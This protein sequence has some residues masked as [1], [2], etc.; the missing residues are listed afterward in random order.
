MVRSFQYRS[1]RLHTRFRIEFFSAN[2]RHTGECTDLSPDGLRARLTTEIAAGTEGW[3]DL[4]I[5]GRTQRVRAVVANLEHDD[6]GFSFRTR[7]P[8]ESQALRDLVSEVGGISW[9][10]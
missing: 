8:E 1:P 9:I 10:D 2:A 7:T 3:L 6:A 4:H 5:P